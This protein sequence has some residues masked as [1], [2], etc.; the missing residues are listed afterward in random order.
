MRRV[1]PC[2]NRRVCRI[3]SCAEP[4]RRRWR[5][6]SGWGSGVHRGLVGW[7]TADCAG[8]LIEVEQ[9][10]RRRRRRFQVDINTASWP[11]LVQLPGV[12]RTLAE[13]I[14][15]SRQ[16]QGPFPDDRGSAPG[17]RHRA[18]D[19]GVHP[20]VSAADAEA[21]GGGAVGEARVI[22]PL[23]LRNA[24]CGPEA[25]SAAYPLPPHPLKTSPLRRYVQARYPAGEI[26]GTAGELV[27]SLRGDGGLSRFC[28]ATA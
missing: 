16:R 24:M 3:G 10:G 14:V 28:G 18:E 5:C 4:I 21:Q 2:L 13:R 20:A 19:A 6:W 8:E 1:R 17:P 7:H 26:P 25:Q 15:E 23:R 27:R 12:G 22:G 9:A 11:E